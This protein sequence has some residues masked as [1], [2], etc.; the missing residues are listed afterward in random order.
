MGH[1]MKILFPSR[2]H[3]R[4]KKGGNWKRK[5][6]HTGLICVLCVPCGCIVSTY[7]AHSSRGWPFCPS[8]GQTGWQ[9]A[10]FQLFRRRRGRFYFWTRFFVCA[11]CDGRGG[12]GKAT[13]A[14]WPLKSGCVKEICLDCCCCCELFESKTEKLGE[15]R[16]NWNGIYKVQFKFSP[17]LLTI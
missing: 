12:S 13:G 16:K 2:P 15:K 17:F 6:P 9:Q 10:G 4:P 5:R 14:G 7:F 8:A 1:E 3:S 11:K